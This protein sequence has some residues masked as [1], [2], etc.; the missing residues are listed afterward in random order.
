M[1]FIISNLFVGIAVFRITFR[2]F[3][4]LIIIIVNLISLKD[5]CILFKHTGIHKNQTKNVLVQVH[6]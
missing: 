1:K 6:N 5:T 3:D 2:L 4:I